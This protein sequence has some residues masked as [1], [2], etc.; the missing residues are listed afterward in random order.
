MGGLLAL[1]FSV[2]FC[3]GTYGDVMLAAAVDLKVLIVEDD[4]STC[5]MMVRLMTRHGIASECA[6]TV[7]E[8]TK[9]DNLVQIAHNV[10]IGR[11]DRGH[12]RA[13][14][15]TRTTLKQNTRNAFGNPFLAW[16]DLAWTMGEMW[17]A[18][19][20]VISHRTA[21]MAA[22]GPTPNGVSVMRPAVPPCGPSA[23][24]R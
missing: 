16:T 15:S 9:I 23:P 21:R 18:S 8:G 11:P 4:P 6:T 5:D 3:N 1:D 14:Q 19:A 17:V 24:I 13:C 2:I 10:I 22:A 7:G 20:Q 12:G